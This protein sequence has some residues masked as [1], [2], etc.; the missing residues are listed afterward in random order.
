MKSRTLFR[1]VAPILLTLMAAAQ[2]APPA[3]DSDI[4]VHVRQDGNHIAVDVDLP[5]EATAIQTWNVMTDYENMAKFVS[6]LQVSRIIEH[7]GNSLLVMQKGK[8]QRGL[9]SFSFENVREIMLTPHSEIRSHLISG[10]LEASD[11]TTSV[12][13]HGESSEIVNHGEFIAKVWVPPIIGPAVIEAA[14]REQF[15]QF[16]AEIMR[17]KMQTAAGRQ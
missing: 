5:V 8:A 17:R 4:D 15:Q 13:D 11:F 16:R 1:A 14:T 2:A 7:D 6:N 9:L 12:V 3:A 10:D